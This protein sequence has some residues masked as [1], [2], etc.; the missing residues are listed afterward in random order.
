M[1]FATTWDAHRNAQLQ[2]WWSQGYSAKMIA[3]KFA[4]DGYFVTRNAVIG[5]THRMR[6]SSPNSK[7]PVEKVERKPFKRVP[8]RQIMIPQ[9]KPLNDIL[10]RSKRDKDMTPP[11]RSKRILLSKTKPQ[12]CRAIV[13]YKHNL[14]A[15]AICCGNK[16]VWIIDGKGHRVRSSWCHYHHDRY[17]QRLEP[18]K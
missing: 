8:N 2:E 9:F 6:L 5:R 14:L 10:L 17:T 4:E 13:D 7:K 11:E 15:K 16:T 1:T 12:H 18:K 3:E